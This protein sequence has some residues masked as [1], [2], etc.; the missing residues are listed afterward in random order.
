MPHSV[1]FQGVFFL[2]HRA[3][4]TVWYLGLAGGL[5]GGLVVVVDG[6][7]AGVVGGAGSG[8]W[9]TVCVWVCWTWF[10][11]MMSGTFWA[12]VTSPG[13]AWPW[14]VLPASFLRSTSAAA[15]TMRVAIRIHTQ[16]AS[17][18]SRWVRMFPPPAGRGCC[19]AAIRC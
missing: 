18:P 10:C 15:P 2:V 13:C 6:G 16:V 4:V 3:T 17:G 1:E 7:G 12:P 11:R 19:G 8:G 5:A 9:V 14:G